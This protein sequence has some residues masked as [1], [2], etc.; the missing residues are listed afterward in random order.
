MLCVYVYIKEKCQPKILMGDLM[1]KIL[2]R[3]SQG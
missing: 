1:K 3:M 2:R